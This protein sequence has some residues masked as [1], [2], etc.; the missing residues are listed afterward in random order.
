MNDRLARILNSPQLKKKVLT[1][2]KVLIILK[3]H[4]I[5]NLFSENGVSII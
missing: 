2:L 5:R 3:Y 1:C 4:V